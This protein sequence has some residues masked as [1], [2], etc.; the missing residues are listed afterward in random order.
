MLSELKAKQQKGQNNTGPMKLV[1]I[2]MHK[3]LQHWLMQ[4]KISAIQK[5]QKRSK[6]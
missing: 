1:V 6:T 2:M 5:T 4:G 3:K